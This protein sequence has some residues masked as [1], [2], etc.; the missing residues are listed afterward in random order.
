MCVSHLSEILEDDPSSPVILT[1]LGGGG[2]YLWEVHPKDR[3]EGPSVAVQ[4]FV[5]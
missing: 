4:R 3:Q 5:T 2:I 1:G